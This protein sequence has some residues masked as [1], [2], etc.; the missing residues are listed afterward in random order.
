MVVSAKVAP[1][2]MHHMPTEC[3]VSYAEIV[4]LQNES[5][6]GAADQGCNPFLQACILHSVCF[7]NACK[8]D[9]INIRADLPGLGKMPE[10]NRSRGDGLN[11]RGGGGLGGGGVGWGDEG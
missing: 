9:M 7:S 10:S 5:L 1:F 8:H 2:H 4:A 6:N 11:K 3:F